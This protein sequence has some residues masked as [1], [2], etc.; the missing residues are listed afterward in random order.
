MLQS[1]KGFLQVKTLDSAVGVM[2]RS[3]GTNG[4]ETMAKSVFLRLADGLDYR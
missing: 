4:S 3:T 1:I 2:Y